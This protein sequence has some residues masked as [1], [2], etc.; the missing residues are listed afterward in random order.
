MVTFGPPESDDYSGLHVDVFVGDERL[1]AG[2]VIG[3]VG[4]TGGGATCFTHE[5]AP[6]GPAAGRR[7][8]GARETS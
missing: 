2:I 4:K 8:A 3:D 1:Q 5:E 7:A 6:L